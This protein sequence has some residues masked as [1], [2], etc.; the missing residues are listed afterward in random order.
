MGAMNLAEYLVD[1][2]D[3]DSTMAVLHA[4]AGPEAVKPGPPYTYELTGNG[5]F[6]EAPGLFLSA[7]IPLALV[8]VRGLAHLEPYLHL[9]LGKVPARLL[10]L[11]V[12]VMATTPDRERYAA[13]GRWQGESYDIRIPLQEGTG[14]HI[15]YEVIPGTIVNIHSHPPGLPAAFSGTDDRDDQG[16]QVSIVVAELDR[17]IPVARARLCVYGYFWE[18]PLGLVFEGPVG[19]RGVDD[20][21]QPW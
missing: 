12:M 2:G 6:L 10:E 16:F 19:V 13:I 8:G 9:C 17:L 11:A 21:S 15:D 1:R 20:E 3:F 14:A 4:G 18:I 7:R 5:L